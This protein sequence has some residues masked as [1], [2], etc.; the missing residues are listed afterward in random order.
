M[1][2]CAIATYKRDFDIKMRDG[3]ICNKESKTN[4]ASYLQILCAKSIRKLVRGSVCFALYETFG[5]YHR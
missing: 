2:A 3:V 5:K 4:L 1:L